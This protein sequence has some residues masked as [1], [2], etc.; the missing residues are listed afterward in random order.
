MGC[1]ASSENNASEAGNTSNQQET[2]AK[3]VNVPAQDFKETRTLKTANNV[4]LESNVISSDSNLISPQ[5]SLEI[6]IPKPTKPRNSGG[7]K[8]SIKSHERKSKELKQVQAWGK[9][10]STTETDFLEDLRTQRRETN[11][12]YE[13]EYE[14][15]E[16]DET[17]R[18]IDG[19]DSGMIID[20][21]SSLS[22]ISN[23]DSSNQV[24]KIYK[25]VGETRSII[26]A[27]SELIVQWVI[28]RKALM[29]PK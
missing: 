26:L 25:E 6:L 21:D 15:S 12:F 2:G 18:F 1:G 19:G 20:D 11:P 3:D 7:K 27:T 9:K 16:V 10:T 17:A 5:E 24:L 28:T 14:I 23:S 29:S 8:S 22:E 13:Q 4:I